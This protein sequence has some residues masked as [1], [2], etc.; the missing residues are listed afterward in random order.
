MNP[1][2]LAIS[3]VFSMRRE[4]KLIAGTIAFLC[5][6]PA[7]SVLLITQTGITPVSR[8]LV[9]NNPETS[10]VDIHD[11]KTG[12]IIEAITAPRVWPVH[13]PVSLEFGES[14]L[15][16]QPM[17]TGIDI[18]SPNHRIGDPVVA[19]MSGTVISAKSTSWGYG[20]HIILDNGNHISS[21]YAHL[22]SLAVMVGQPVELGTV[23]GL[24]GSTG[25]STGPHLHFEVRVFGIPV[26][27]RTFLSG[28]P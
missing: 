6:L 15:P 25:W 14:D 18:A 21:Y 13:G 23:L 9:S 22:D 8:A 27:P 5:F 1:W 28:N 3:G 24:R 17:H 12:I 7:A 19:F 2:F 26:N 16:Y 11:P 20:K 10:Q 4:L